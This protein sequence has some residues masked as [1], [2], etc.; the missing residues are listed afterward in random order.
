MRAYIRLFTGA[1]DERVYPVA[2]FE[3]NDCYGLAAPKATVLETNSSYGVPTETVLQTNTSYGVSTTTSREIIG[4]GDYIS[5]DEV[6]S[7]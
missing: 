4:D 1:G 2:E 3:T 6:A 5:I 7:L